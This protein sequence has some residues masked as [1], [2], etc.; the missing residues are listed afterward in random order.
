MPKPMQF[1]QRNTKPLG[2]FYQFESRQAYG[3][4]FC[5]GDLIHQAP[6]LLPA[7]YDKLYTLSCR[8]IL[9]NEYHSPIP[10]ELEHRGHNK[11]LFKRE[12]SR[13]LWERYPSLKL[14]DH[15]FVWR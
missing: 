15:R 5:T 1:Y 2:S 3:L 8:Y 9:A 14:V 4:A 6:N 12:F 7:L 10:I 13:E 11:K